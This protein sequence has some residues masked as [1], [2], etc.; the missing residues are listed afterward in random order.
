MA[1]KS[2]FLHFK[3]KASYNKERAKT[4]A[5]SEERKVFDAYISYVDEGP[6]IYTWGKE[7][8]CD[9]SASEVQNLINNNKITPA[10]I[11]PIIAGK[12][13]VGSSTK[14]AREDHV[15]P[16]QTTI[17][18]NA[19]SATRLETARTISLNGDVTGS[20]SF[21][22]S[23]NATITTTV[24]ND[25]HTH[26]NSTITSVDA[27]KITSGIINIERLPKG[28]LERLVIVANKS[29]R[30]ALTSNDVQ[31]GDTVKQTDTGVMYFVININKLNSEDGYSVYT[32][33]SATSVPW[34]G[35]TG[36]PNFATVATSGS[37]N[38]L[39]NKP[40][41]PTKTSQLT[42]DSQF[43]TNTAIVQTTGTSTTQVMSQKAT[44]DAINNKVNNIK[45]GG[46]NLA[47]DSTKVITNTSSYTKYILAVKVNELKNNPVYVSY[48]YEYS[49]VSTGEEWT[50][51]R[52]G[53][54]TALLLTDGSYSYSFGNSFVLDKNATGLSGSGR[55]LA[56]PLMI[57]SNAVGD[58]QHISF[59]FQIKSGNVRIY[60]VKLEQG[61]IPTAW[62]PT[63]EDKQDKLIS[64]YNIKTVNGVSLLGS[65]NIAES[66]PVFNAWKNNRSVALGEKTAT[67]DW[68]VAIGPSASCQL[69]GQVAIG[70]ASMVTNPFEITLGDH[71]KT[72]KGLHFSVAAPFNSSVGRKNCF[73]ILD[74]GNFRIPNLQNKESDGL[75]NL[76]EYISSKQDKLISGTNIKTIKGQS[77]LGSGDISVVGPTGPKG[78]PGVNAT[79]TSATAS[80]GN[81]VG[82]PNVKVSLGGTP[83]ARTF[84]FAFSNL[85]GATGSKGDTG[86]KGAT[87][88]QG[89][90]GPKGDVGPQGPA[91]PGLP[92]VQVTGTSTTSAMSQKAVTDAINIITRRM[93]SSQ[94]LTLEEF[95]SG[96]RK[97][98]PDKIIE[99]TVT[100]NGTIKMPYFDFDELT[101]NFVEW[102]GEYVVLLHNNGQSSVNI[103]IGVEGG[104]VKMVLIDKK[105]TLTISANNYG[106]INMIGR[107]LPN[108]QIVWFVRSA[109][110]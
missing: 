105:D 28:A 56:G 85:K 1:Y 34:S 38:D 61:N 69:S 13:T 60:N 10:T 83:S 82:T 15:H 9:I 92:L 59:F 49:D 53:F 81:T 64:G 102:G 44:T 89:P 41:I 76:Q 24:A 30:F 50:K 33:G 22:G 14:Y 98:T 55:H 107:R 42:N 66:D 104:S 46:R 8:K 78:D 48:D 6:T 74:N 75:G 20:T 95:N 101:P 108:Q 40:T 31:E 51:C 88:P 39:T 16:A 43:I 2:K 23:S 73:E 93:M 17:T 12:A 19:G 70:S 32:A 54:E 5:G 96:M 7:Y 25:S 27:S 47:L 52:F 35:I 77:I 36:K 109:T 29:A 68:S 58:E 26:S 62:T 3:T 99:I 100:T 84:D 106:E 21:N 110:L 87:G 79:I 72:Y 18:G 86:P 80:V 91:G 94:E 103:A 65:G 11:A 90:A 97:L 63:P 67:A 4:V 71:N 57:P 45:I 37:Y